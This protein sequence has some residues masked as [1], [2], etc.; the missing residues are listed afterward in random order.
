MAQSDRAIRWA[1]LDELHR[2][3]EE[4]ERTGFPPAPSDEPETTARNS[5]RTGGEQAAARGG[6][7]LL[8]RLLANRERRGDDGPNRPP[9]MACLLD[10]D[11]DD[12]GRRRR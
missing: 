6:R 4:L 7:P 9:R 8:R 11:G 5:A 1:R 12:R 2:L 3:R 10:R